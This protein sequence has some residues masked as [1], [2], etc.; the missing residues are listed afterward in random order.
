MATHNFK[1]CCI[2]SENRSIGDS[3]NFNFNLGGTHIRAKSVELLSVFIPHSFYN[4]SQQS[5]NNLF[6]LKEEGGVETE[7]TLQSGYY[8]TKNPNSK[9]ITPIDADNN[10]YIRIAKEINK[11]FSRT[12][13]MYS[14]VQNS[15]NRKLTIYNMGCK[16]FILEFPSNSTLEKLLGGNDQHIYKSIPLNSNSSSQQLMFPN[17]TPSGTNSVVTQFH[18]Y[19]EAF[20]ETLVEVLCDSVRKDLL[21]PNSTFSTFVVPT[22]PKNSFTQYTHNNNFTQRINFGEQGRDINEIKVLLRDQRGQT[23]DLNGSDWYF[24]VKFELNQN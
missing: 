4:V 1:I 22:D 24:I 18:I 16:E 13:S 15:I 3:N 21:G 17:T 8:N 10:L 20:G 12:Y 9:H 23:I 5:N 14:F 6:S 11:K 2:N 19:C 7:I